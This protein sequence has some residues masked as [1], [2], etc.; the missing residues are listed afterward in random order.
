MTARTID[1]AEAERI[2]LVNRV[3]APDELE[4]RDAG[5]RR[6]A[7]RQLAHRRRPRQA[8]DRRLGAPGARADARDG[9][10][11][12]GVLRRRRARERARGRAGQHGRRVER[13][14][15]LSSRRRPGAL[16]Q[17]Q[18]TGPATSVWLPSGRPRIS[19]TRRAQASSAGRSMPVCDAHLVQHRDEVLGGDVAGRPGRHRAAA[20]LAEARLEALDAG[21]QRGEHVGEAL[22]ARVVEVRGQ[23]DL[24]AQR[25]RAR[26]EE[27]AD[28]ARVGHPGGVAEAD[29]LRAGVAQARGDL[30]HA[31]GRHVALVGAAEGRRDHALAAQPRLARAAE[32]DLQLAERLG[33]RAVDV[34]AVV[35]LGG[36]QEDVDLV[37]P[38]ALLRAPRCRPR[39][40]GISTLTAT[41]SGTSIRASTS[42]ASAS[43]GIT[44]ARTKLVTSR[45]RR[46]VRASASISST[47]SVGRDRLGLVL[48]AVARADLADP[49][50]LR[51]LL[52]RRSTIG[53]SARSRGRSRRPSSIA[54][55]VATRG[56]SGGVS[57][58][59]SSSKGTIARHA[60][61]TVWRCLPASTSRDTATPSQ[62]ISSS[63]DQQRS[64]R[65][66]RSAISCSSQ[67]RVTSTPA[68]CSASAAKSVRRPAADLG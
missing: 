36:R 52:H 51:R 7:A 46:P 54:S 3:V 9:G 24:L 53:P 31:L 29:L 18:S 21:L 33:D 19:C 16:A 40:L 25:D 61:A 15:R 35:R 62:P 49:H 1:A 63:I 38:L 30:E 4:Q 11:R 59:H 45:R 41:S 64:V 57:L 32:H 60:S 44:S 20:E 42:A 27:L 12:A 13:S 48:K 50:S 55:L 66:R 65:A 67:S 14:R 34:L 6:R 28:L 43:C 58:S 39:S 17:R 26:R 5:A 47:L 2:G 22:P 8:R 68:I 23:L 37:D 56:S 10:R